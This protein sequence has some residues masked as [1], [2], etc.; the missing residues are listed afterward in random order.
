MK[1]ILLR[2]ALPLS[3]LFALLLSSTPASALFFGSKTETGEAAVCAFSKNGLIGERIVFS[4]ADFQVTPDSDTI[5]DAIVITALPAS[6]AG[7]LTLANQELAVGDEIAMS[8]VDGLRFLSTTAPEVQ[9]TSFSFTPIFSNGTAGQEVTAQLHLLASANHVPIAENLELDT[10]KNVAITGRFSAIDPEGDLLTYQ[11]VRKPA[12][13]AITMPEDGSADFVYTPY[14]NK[15]GK[16][17]FTYVAVDAVGNT[18]APA[19][20][21]I[22]IEKAGTKVTYADMQGVPAC[23]AAI[24]LAEEGIFIGEN[25]GGSYFFQPELPVSRGEFVAM[26]MHACGIAPLEG[27]TVTGFADDASIPVWAK[28]YLSSALKSGLVQGSRNEAGQV[29]FDAESAITQA[30]A[31]VLLN[32]MLRIA[33]VAVPTFAGEDQNVPAWASQS[34]ANLASCGVLQPDNTG[35]LSLNDP[36]TRADAAQL[37]CGALEV[38]DRRESSW[39]HF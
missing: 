28:P 29:I 9:T 26:A 13:G 35:A 36:L 19:T 39:F 14:E 38:L 5:L 4:Q 20:V 23:K 3:L 27:V 1:H 25:R 2:R 15:T 10:Y 22:R 7:V 33:D 31:A 11:L 6:G 16:D 18:S 24:R 37:L 30:E 21:K 8:A 12:R 17:T 34:A 32:R